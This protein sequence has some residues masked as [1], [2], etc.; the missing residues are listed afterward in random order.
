MKFMTYMKSKE[1][2]L[3]VSL[4]YQPTP[5]VHFK[6]DEDFFHVVV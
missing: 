2:T 3:N 6:F 4:I 5:C 1:S